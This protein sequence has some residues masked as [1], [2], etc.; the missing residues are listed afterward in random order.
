MYVLFDCFSA[1]Y[2]ILDAWDA[3]NLGPFGRTEQTKMLPVR[4]TLAQITWSK[5]VSDQPR[6]ALRP[7][8]EAIFLTGDMALLLPQ[9]F[10]S[11]SISGNLLKCWQFLRGQRY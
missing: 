11:I 5:A 6:S 4:T 8:L 10:A 7:G 1:T 9:P 2:F 3:A